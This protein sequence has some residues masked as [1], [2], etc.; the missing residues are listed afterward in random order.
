REARGMDPQ[1]RLVLETSWEALESAG[2][3]AE[4]VSGSETGVF[5]GLMYHEYEG[6]LA[7]SLESLDGYVLTG[8]AAS[9]AS[10][11]VSYALGLKGPS[12]TVDTACSSSLVTV[13]LACESLRAGECSLALAG[14]VTL[15]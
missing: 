15:M 5:V 8:S 10:G 4:T 6:L 7:R 14:G 11:R 1:H 9:V 12:L 3:V 13:H 2:V